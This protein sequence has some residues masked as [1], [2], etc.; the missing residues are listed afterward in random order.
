VGIRKLAPLSSLF[1]LLMSSVPSLGQKRIIVALRTERDRVFSPRR[2]KRQTRKFRWS[3]CKTKVKEKKRSNNVYKFLEK[4]KKKQSFFSLSSLSLFV[5]PSSRPLLSATWRPRPA[6]PRALPARV[7]AEAA[8]AA[9]A[10]ALAAA[11]LRSAASPSPLSANLPLL[12][13]PCALS[14]A[15]PRR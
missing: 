3:S 15:S 12:L 10:A 7:A 2:A 13:R 5:C 6:A 14:R 4:K 8:A 1:F 9:A 11:L